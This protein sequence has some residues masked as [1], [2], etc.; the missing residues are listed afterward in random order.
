MTK[1]TFVLFLC[2]FQT[3]AF[4][5]LP[6]QSA[7][8]YTSENGTIEFYP[9]A[10]YDLR[11]AQVSDAC[12][13]VCCD[14]TPIVQEHESE[15]KENLSDLLRHRHSS[16]RFVTFESVTTSGF[17]LNIGSKPS[18]Y[19]SQPIALFKGAI[20]LPD[21]YSFLHRLCPF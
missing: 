7:G 5:L 4:S 9:Y 14:N 17:H 11:G 3:L 15:W 21:Y 13:D 18:I 20:T 1:R 10:T 19:S 8:A 16:Y 6:K 12:E 2:L